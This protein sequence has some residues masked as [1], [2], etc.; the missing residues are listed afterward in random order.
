MR[1]GGRSVLREY[2]SANP[3]HVLVD[4]RWATRFGSAPHVSTPS[5]FVKLLAVSRHDRK[6]RASPRA[7]AGGRTHA[8]CAMA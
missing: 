2:V 4:G 7:P 8:V 5:S 3:L 6:M 1:D